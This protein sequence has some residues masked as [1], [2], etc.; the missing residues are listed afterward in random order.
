MRCSQDP[1]GSAGGSDVGSTAEEPMVRGLCAG[2][3][4]IR[5]IGP[6]VTCELCWRGLSLLPARERERF[7]LAF[8]APRTTPSSRAGARFEQVVACC[9]RGGFRHLAVQLIYTFALHRLDQQFGER[10]YQGIPK[11]PSIGVASSR[12]PVTA[13]LPSSPA[14]STRCAVRSR[15][16][17]R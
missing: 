7:S 10:P 14:S 15:C 16:S 13:S 5:T 4:W 17:W 8:S 12:L 2:G 9:A 6:P 11:S 3:R 1:V